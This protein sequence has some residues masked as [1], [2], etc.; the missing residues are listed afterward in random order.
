[1]AIKCIVFCKVFT[2]KIFNLKFY[3]Y[4]S[5]Q[6]YL[7]E[8]PKN[9]FFFVV[10]ITATRIL[11]TNFKDLY[12]TSLKK[13][14]KKLRFGEFDSSIQSREKI[15]NYLHDHEFDTQNITEPLQSNKATN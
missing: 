7:A 12:F 5:R 15:Q 11:L 13:K 4:Y 1:M 6:R 9:Y 14:K 2:L 8:S 3:N 10:L